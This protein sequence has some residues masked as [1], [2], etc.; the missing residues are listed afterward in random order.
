VDTAAAVASTRLARRSDQ[1]YRELP[2]VGRR[3]QFAAETEQD[4]H[5]GRG[6]EYGRADDDPAQTEEEE[7]QPLQRSEGPAEGT[8]FAVVRLR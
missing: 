7:H 8:R 4:V 2:W 6:G 5:R 3:Q 1:A